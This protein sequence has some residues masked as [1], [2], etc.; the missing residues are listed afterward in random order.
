MFD[1]STERT[2]I[3]SAIVLWFAHGWYLN[4]R[5]RNVHRKLDSILDNFDGLRT[6]LYENDPQFDDERDLL[7]E[8]GNSLENGTVSFAGM[9]HME[10]TKQK[11]DSGRRTLD[12]RF[13]D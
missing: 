11:E 3:G 13:A 7:G 6:Y 4:T 2:I 9:N 8:L 12:T 10:L 1:T 5:L